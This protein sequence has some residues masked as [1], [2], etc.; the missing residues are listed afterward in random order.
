MGSE[1][2]LW[3]AFIRGQYGL[4]HRHVG[5][6]HAPDAAMALKH[7]RDVYTRRKKNVSIWVVPSNRITTSDEVLDPYKGHGPRKVY[8]HPSFREALMPAPP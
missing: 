8:P 2:P 4:N 1:W 3:G 6:P 5:A 7:A